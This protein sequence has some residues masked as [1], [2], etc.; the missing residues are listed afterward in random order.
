MQRANGLVI[1][2]TAALGLLACGGPPAPAQPSDDP[3]PAIAAHLVTLAERDNGT[4][5]P[6]DVSSGMRIEFARQ[7]HDSPWSAE[8]RACLR[9]AQTQDET[10]TCP[11]Q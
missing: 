8:R 2:V 5:A 4:D 9:L 11:Q 3:C 1:A 10:A 7:C 6:A